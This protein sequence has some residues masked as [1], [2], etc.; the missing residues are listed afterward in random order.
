MHGTDAAEVWPIVVAALAGAAATSS[1]AAG[2]SSRPS[3]RAPRP[4]AIAPAPEAWGLVVMRQD[5]PATAP[6]GRPR[7]AEPPVGLRRPHGGH[8]P[9]NGPQVRDG[10]AQDDEANRPTR[11]SA[12]PRG[13][14][15]TETPQGWHSACAPSR[16]ATRHFPGRGRWPARD[17]ARLAAPACLTPHRFRIEGLR[18]DLGCAA[19]KRMQIGRSP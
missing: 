3:A 15:R 17:V 13:A 14:P 8:P 6:G 5:S 18:R 16:G 11:R 7:T 19:P 1:T 9:A 12:P 4:P 2:T 10:Q